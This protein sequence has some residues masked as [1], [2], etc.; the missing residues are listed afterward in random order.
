MVDIGCDDL[1]R[2]VSG[3]EFGGTHHAACRAV[4]G[5]RQIINHSSTLTGLQRALHGNRTAG[6]VDVLYTKVAVDFQN[7]EQ[8]TAND[9][10]STGLEVIQGEFGL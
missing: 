8:D 6:G 9:V 2:C 1:I 5:A 4:A 3:V 7:L 10:L